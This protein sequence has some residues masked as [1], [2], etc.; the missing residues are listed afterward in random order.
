MATTRLEKHLT[1]VF[2][3]T[4]KTINGSGTWTPTWKRIRYSTIFALN[5]NPQT[6]T[7]D[8]IA[9][10]APT[11]EVIKN[12]PE[13]PQ[14]STTYEGDPAF[15][16]LYELYKS[17]PVGSAVIVPVLICFGGASKD[18]WQVKQATIIF[19]EFNTVDRKLSFTF[20]LGGTIE[21]GTYTISDGTP[22]FTAS[23]DS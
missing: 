20:K 14:E 2:I 8:Y 23:T 22:S 4:S 19:G 9:D 16:F 11:E 18:A 5:M 17:R 13:L 6:E 7:R 21:D 3:D 15:D 10:E 1:P 12:Q